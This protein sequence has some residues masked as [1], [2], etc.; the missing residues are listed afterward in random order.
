MSGLKGGALL[1]VLG[2][3]LAGYCALQVK[4]VARTGAPSDEPPERGPSKEQ[5]DAGRA[6][7]A[8]LASDVGKA[9]EVAEQYRAAGPADAASDPAAAAVVKA[10]A[11]RSADLADLDTFLADRERPTFSGQLKEQYAKWTEE[12]RALRGDERA[13]AE[14]LARPPEIASA[15]DAAKASEALDSLI[16][17]YATRSNFSDKAR[18]AVWRVQARLIVADGLAALADKEYRA[19]IG[20]KL[21]LKPND[22]AEGTLRALKKAIEEL[23]A[24]ARA[25]AADAKLD[26]DLRKAV[27]AKGAAADENAARE[28]LL[29]LLA[30]AD[31]FTDPAGA[32]PWLKEVAAKYARTKRDA[33]RALIRRKVQEFCEAF[34]PPEVRLDDAVIFDGK[35]VERKHVVVAYQREVGGKVMRAPLSA[36]LDGANEFNLAKTHPGDTTFV[37]H[38]G[39]TRRPA[40]LKPT[41]LSRAAALYNAERKKLS[42]GTTEPKWTEKSVLELKKK[43]EAQQKQVEN[44]EVLGGG[45]GGKPFKLWTRL[46]G[47]ARGLG[48]NKELVAPGP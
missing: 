37:E 31:L 9:A 3:P 21:P 44:L 26:P 46:T 41:E 47:L 10:G 23:D 22:P 39:S 25:A 29:S 5:L 27:D 7:S 45:S 8:A 1:L 35:E 2:I 19:A 34:V 28:E 20:Q 48:A 6:K 11:A 16:E 4:G 42:D 15:A 32:A 30:K 12:R 14:R 36:E 43:C 24:A 18:A 17:Q 40:A 33:D 38:M 13:V